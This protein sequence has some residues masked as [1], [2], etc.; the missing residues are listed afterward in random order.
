MVTVT[1]DFMVGSNLAVWGL[2]VEMDDCHLLQASLSHFPDCSPWQDVLSVHNCKN[3]VG[4]FQVVR[5]TRTLTLHKANL[6]ALN[7]VGGIKLIADSRLYGLLL[8][9]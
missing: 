3:G 5:A 9:K 4:V 1:S 6:V 8:I 2:T 7:S